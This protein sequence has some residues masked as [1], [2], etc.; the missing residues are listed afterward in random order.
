MSGE[1]MVLPT[2]AIATRRVPSGNDLVHIWMHGMVGGKPIPPTSL[3]GAPY[4]GR[5]IGD[6]D[7]RRPKCSRCLEEMEKINGE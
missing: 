6:H 7:T 5:T 4:D 2:P 1:R 3:C